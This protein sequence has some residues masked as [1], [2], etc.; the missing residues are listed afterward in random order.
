MAALTSASR[1]H[2]K[3]Y[4]ALARKHRCCDGGASLALGSVMLEIEISLA[5]VGYG[6]NRYSKLFAIKSASAAGIK[7]SWSVP[8]LFCE[9][10]ILIVQIIIIDRSTNGGC[11]NNSTS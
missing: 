4:I 2:G 9:E 8:L 11:K 5:V 10:T 7:L 3:R 1:T 6:G